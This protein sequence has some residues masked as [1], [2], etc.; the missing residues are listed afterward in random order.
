M[1]KRNMKSSASLAT[2]IMEGPEHCNISSNGK[3]TP[4]ATTPGSQQRKFM[5][6]TSSK[7]TIEDAH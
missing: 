4:R 1:G 7:H 3:D 5:P 2:D 6:Q